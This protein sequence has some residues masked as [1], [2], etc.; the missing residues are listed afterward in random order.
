MKVEFLYFAVLILLFLLFAGQLLWSYFKRPFQ[1]QVSGYKHHHSH[2][3]FLHSFKKDYPGFRLT[4]LPLVR[5]KSLAEFHPGHHQI[6]GRDFEGI[7]CQLEIVRIPKDLFD[8]IAERFDRFEEHDEYS[9]SLFKEDLPFNSR[10]MQH[11]VFELNHLIEKS[12]ARQG[13]TVP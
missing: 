10:Q 6:T 3:L 11:F 7:V 5:G 12:F 9:L 8:K 2:D 1:M 13:E 4:F